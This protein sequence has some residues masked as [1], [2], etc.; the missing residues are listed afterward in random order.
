MFFLAKAVVH[1]NKNGRGIRRRIGL[2]YLL[3]G[4][5]FSFLFYF[6]EKDRT[7]ALLRIGCL[8]TSLLITENSFF[9]TLVLKFRLF[10]CTEFFQ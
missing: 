9:I 5:D 3:K 1:F 2:I 10:F 4:L 7:L 8:F 6:G